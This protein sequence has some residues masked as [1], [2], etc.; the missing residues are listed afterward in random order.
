LDRSASPRLVLAATA[1]VLLL[2]VLSAC[3]TP[4]APQY[5]IVKQTFEIRFVSG[6][7]PEIKLH[8]VYTLQNTGNAGLDFVDVVFPA[9]KVYGRTNLTVQSGGRALTP[10]DLPVEYQ[11]DSP[12]ALRLPLDSR[13]PQK[14]KRDLVVD[15]SFSP[16]RAGGEEFALGPQTFHLGTRG[17]LPV[18]L[19]PNHIFAAAPVRPDKLSYAVRVP[20]DFTVLARG[21]AASRQQDG[22]D[23]IYRFSLDKRDLGPYVVAGHY[24]PSHQ[25]NK[26]SEA[27]FWTLENVPQNATSQPNRFAAAWS[28]LQK[29]FGEIDK[30]TSAPYIVETPTLEADN[31]ASGDAAFAAFPGGVLINSAALGLGTDNEI[32]TER[33]ERGLARTWFDDALQPAPFAALALGD[34]LPAYATIVIDDAAGGDSARRKRIAALLNSY[35]GAHSQLKVPEKSVVATL[36]TD[37]LE[38]RRIA[39]AKAPLLFV[40]LEDSCGATPVRAGLAQAIQLL[41]GKE[42]SVNDIRAAIEYTTGK[43]LAEPFRGWLYNP[44]IPS[45]FRARYLSAAGNEKEQTE[46]GN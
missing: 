46:N 16:P 27:V 25:T 5:Q 23:T 30:R 44:G 28:V 34:G 26:S 18:F 31:S 17:W 14:E 2:C 10:V 15:Y 39:E 11:P 41:R 33:V 3:A 37:S 6:S 22:S 45:D 35:D 20:S 8:N 42:V 19:P 40:A 13:W 4:L 43:N 38:Q 24:A 1:T 12:G 29:N 7:N 9:A 36:L 21:S 32:F